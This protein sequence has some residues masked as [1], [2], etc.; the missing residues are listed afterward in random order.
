MQNYFNLGLC[1][2]D[3]YSKKKKTQKKWTVTKR[4]S[5]LKISLNRFLLLFDLISGPSVCPFQRPPFK[6]APVCGQDTQKGFQE[7]KRTEKNCD[8]QQKVAPYLG[9]YLMRLSHQKKKERQTFRLTCSLHSRKPFK[10]IYQTNQ[11]FFFLEKYLIERFRIENKKA[12]G[13]D[14]HQELLEAS[15]EFFFFYLWSTQIFLFMRNKYKPH[16]Q[17]KKRQMV[18][19]HSR[20]LIRPFFGWFCPVASRWERDRLKWWYYIL[21]SLQGRRSSLT[22]TII[23]TISELTGM[24]AFAGPLT[25]MS[26]FIK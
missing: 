24:T 11:T 20:L 19:S 2:C 4:Q 16:S 21:K 7:K 12:E 14:T 9:G 8:Q 3:P 22:Q 15:R 17:E 10:S 26:S 18:R 25:T 23:D 5:S 6:G 1:A 13:F